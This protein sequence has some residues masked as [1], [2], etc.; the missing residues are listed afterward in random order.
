MNEFQLIYGTP[1]PG[2]VAPPEKIPTAER[3]AGHF[4]AAGGSRAVDDFASPML[5]AQM[6]ALVRPDITPSGAAAVL[7]ELAALVGFVTL[8]LAGHFAGTAD[9]ADELFDA[10]VTRQRGTLGI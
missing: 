7:A 1:N 5:Q 2:Y 8:E 10:L 9:P 6:A 3:V 4:L